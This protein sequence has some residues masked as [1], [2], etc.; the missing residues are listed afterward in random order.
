[1]DGTASLPRV[2]LVL[3]TT[4]QNL[5][6]ALCTCGTLQGKQRCCRS[7]FSVVRPD[8]DEWCT[9]PKLLLFWMLFLRS[10]GSA[11]VPSWREVKSDWQHYCKCCCLVPWLAKSYSLA[12]C[13]LAT[14]RSW[15]FI[16]PGNCLS[17]V[18]SNKTYDEPVVERLGYLTE[19]GNASVRQ[20]PV[21]L[22]LLVVGP[23]L[24]IS[25]AGFA[26]FSTN[27]HI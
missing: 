13:N 14:R 6:L 23:T 16:L 19:G 1:M 17:R 5:L 11:A 27:L 10:R 20:Y 2:K 7:L 15:F 4:G 26:S 18:A 21:L 22:R 9:G 3:A 24:F 8:E 12:C 25:Q